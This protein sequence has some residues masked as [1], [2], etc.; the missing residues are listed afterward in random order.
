MSH[1]DDSFFNVSS[2]VVSVIV[3]VTAVRRVIISISTVGGGTLT[4]Q[5]SATR[6]KEKVLD[7]G[8]MKQKGG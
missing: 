4:F 6:T 2:D 3:I 1:D 5:N 7:F 8:G